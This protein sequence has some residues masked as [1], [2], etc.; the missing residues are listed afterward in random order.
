LQ[1]IPSKNLTFTELQES[2]FEEEEEENTKLCKVKGRNQ[3]EDLP[4]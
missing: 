1:Q 3:T 2:S 4:C